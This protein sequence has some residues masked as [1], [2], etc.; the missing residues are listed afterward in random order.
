M[1]MTATPLFPEAFAVPRPRVDA[2][3]RLS[4]RVGLTATLLAHLML[5]LL[6]LR[7]DPMDSQTATPGLKTLSAFWV[8]APNIAP[9]VTQAAAPSPRISKPRP[10]TPKAKPKLQTPA[11]A[12]DARIAAVTPTPTVTAAAR[13]VAEPEAAETAATAAATTAAIAA[14]AASPPP[15][16]GEA[17][18]LRST[19]T[20]YDLEKLERQYARLV[21]RVISMNQRYPVYSKQ[22][23]ETG[24]IMV[25]V[26][27]SQDGSVRNVAMMTPSGYRYLDD[28]ARNVILRIARF[29]AVPALLMRG[30]SIFVIDQPI[31][32][33]PR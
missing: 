15:A 13:P 20:P 17:S 10:P 28:E 4:R 8:P 33:G 19:A 6:F 14:V 1:L 25:R 21:S 24:L 23:G 12:A 18:N 2:A 30:Q 9:T 11:P 31:R 29:P 16:A 27:L 5:F 7:T 32:F 3:P 22:F 26:D